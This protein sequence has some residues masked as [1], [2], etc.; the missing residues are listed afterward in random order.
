MGLGIG[1][2]L[3]GEEG[4][5]ESVFEGEATIGADLIVSGHEKIKF[6]RRKP[7]CFGDGPPMRLRLTRGQ[8][9]LLRVADARR[10]RGVFGRK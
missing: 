9:A 7:N 2:A 5:A 1:F 10:E 8:S 6:E 4:G 3:A